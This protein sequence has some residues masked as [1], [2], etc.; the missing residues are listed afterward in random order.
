MT[1][2][3]KPYL[4]PITGSSFAANHIIY[5]LC[6][7][8]VLRCAHLYKGKALYYIQD[9][10]CWI[11]SAIVCTNWTCNLGFG[12]VRPL[13][14]GWSAGPQRSEDHSAQGPRRTTLHRAGVG[15]SL[16]L[17]TQLVRSLVLRTSFYSLRPLCG[18]S[19]K[20]LQRFWCSEAARVP[21]SR[22]L[23]PASY[24]S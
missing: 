21:T 16:P 8:V 12:P 7:A 20:S 1:K 2:S 6:A 13:Y 10:K 15:H 17:V 4:L 5:S 14:K 9:V 19:H 11:Y 18:V 3:S 24:K 22:L 23:R